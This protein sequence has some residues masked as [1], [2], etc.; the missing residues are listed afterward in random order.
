MIIPGKTSSATLLAV[1]AVIICAFIQAGTAVPDQ[2]PSS[3]NRLYKIFSLLLCHL[4][5]L[6]R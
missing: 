4:L 2:G 3:I 5:H 1:V 6:V